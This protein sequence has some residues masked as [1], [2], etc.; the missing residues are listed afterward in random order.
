VLGVLL[1]LAG[2]LA[3]V[4]GL[5]G[6]LLPALPGPPVSAVGPLLVHCGVWAITGVASPIG[7]ALVAVASVLGVLATGV[8]LG[9][10]LIARRLATSNRGATLGAYYG[11]AIGVLG[12]GGLAVVGAGGSLITL[13]ASLVV[14][15]VVAIGL[16]ISGPFAGAFLGQLAAQPDPDSPSVTDWVEHPWRPEHGVFP[17]LREAALS[18]AAQ[19]VSLLLTTTAKVAYGGLAAVISLVLGLLALL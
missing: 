13:G 1:V 17:L 2:A 12:A 15:T 11:L 3:L 19:V 4:V 8:E 7:W 9:A 5:L 6:S 16:L 18:G 10:P 14:S